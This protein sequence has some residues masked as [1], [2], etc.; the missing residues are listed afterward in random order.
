M[1]HY[2]K[3]LEFD[4]G[5]WYINGKWTMLKAPANNPPSE[6]SYLEKRYWAN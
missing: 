1:N 2:I 6:W 5:Y 4:W 3:T